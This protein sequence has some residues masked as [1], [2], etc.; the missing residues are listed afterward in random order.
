MAS[1]EGF[2]LSCL[3]QNACLNRFRCLSSQA[4]APVRKTQHAIRIHERDPAYLKSSRL[5]ILNLMTRPA[6]AGH[7][8]SSL[9]DEL[10]QGLIAHA[11]VLPSIYNRWVC[12]SLILNGVLFESHYCIA[13]S[14]SSQIELG[15]RTCVMSAT[16]ITR[17]WLF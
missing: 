3:S 17:P 9:E 5:R 13:N 6:S 15:R 4:H 11:D 8:A 10:G 7:G 14:F 16:Y 2:T 1:C 12:V